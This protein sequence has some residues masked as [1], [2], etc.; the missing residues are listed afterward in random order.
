MALFSCCFAPRSLDEDEAAPVPKGQAEHVRGKLAAAACESGVKLPAVSPKGSI[1]ALQ[2]LQIPS[3]DDVM[4]MHS[5][6]IAVANVSFAD[7]LCSVDTHRDSPRNRRGGS[8]RT[9]EAASCSGESQVIFPRLRGRLSDTGDHRD[10]PACIFEH[11]EL[12]TVREQ[13]SPPRPTAQRDAQ[14]RDTVSGSNVSVNTTQAA[15]TTHP[16]LHT[17][18]R[19]RKTARAAPGS[20]H[21]LPSSAYRGTDTKAPSSQAHTTGTLMRMHQSLEDRARRARLPSY[22]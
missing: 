1:K 15:P 13:P 10:Q 17:Q 8:S 14:P 2:P 11:R 4:E 6:W 9:S 16:S 18:Q 3:E 22:Q 5:S 12:P 20:H 21:T 19:P 7:M